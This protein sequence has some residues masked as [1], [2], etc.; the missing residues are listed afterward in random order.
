MQRVFP[1]WR[2]S[3]AVGIAISLVAYGSEIT[4]V[5]TLAEENVPPSVKSAPATHRQQKVLTVAKVE[6]GE[7][8]EDFCLDSKGRILALLGPNDQN[9]G[10]ALPATPGISAGQKQKF[11]S[12]VHVYDATGHLVAKWAIGFSGQAI[13][14]A[15]DGTILIGGDGHVA[16]FSQGGNARASKGA[17]GV[18]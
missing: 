5:T 6:A 17:I 10:I 18:G 8:L 1:G 2:T 12:A 3:T 13:N 9:T 15:P 4:E 14:T 11:E 16:R 7:K